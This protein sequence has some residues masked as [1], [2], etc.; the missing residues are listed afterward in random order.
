[1]P[2]YIEIE[3][4]IIG[5]NDEVYN[6]ITWT[7]NGL[8]RLGTYAIANYKL[9]NIANPN[10]YLWYTLTI[11]QDV[12]EIWLD[13]SVIDDYIIASNDKFIVVQAP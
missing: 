8:D 5:L 13:D 4:I 12:L 3:P 7:V 11:P 1:M 10:Q 6:A 9:F 2:N